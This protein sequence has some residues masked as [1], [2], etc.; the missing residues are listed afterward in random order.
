VY[1]GDVQLWLRLRYVLMDDCHQVK[2]ARTGLMASLIVR[3]ANTR[4]L[5]ANFDPQIMALIRE[6]E[7][8]GRMGLD[9]PHDTR[10][11]TAQ[12]AVYKKLYNDVVVSYIFYT[13]QGRQWVNGLSNSNGYGSGGLAR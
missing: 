11:L 8:I 12:R 5:A 13:I 3:Q 1:N 2:A 10:M 4:E 9:V 7:H 6:T